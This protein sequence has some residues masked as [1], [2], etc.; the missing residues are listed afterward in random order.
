MIV[1]LAM[2]SKNFEGV[3]FVDGYT[4]ETVEFEIDGISAYQIDER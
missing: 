3:G 1:D 2:G 4:P